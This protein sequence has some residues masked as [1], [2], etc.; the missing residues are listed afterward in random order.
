MVSEPLVLQYDTAVTEAMDD[1]HNVPTLH[2]LVILE[3]TSVEILET[4]Y[5]P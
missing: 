4:V 2:M 3:F 5:L 1:A